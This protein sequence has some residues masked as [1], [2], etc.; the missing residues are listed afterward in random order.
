MAPQPFATDTMDPMSI[1]SAALNLHELNT[2]QMFDTQ[3]AAAGLE[4]QIAGFFSE[5]DSLVSS[6]EFESLFKRRR[7]SDGDIFGSDEQA[8]D[9]FDQHEMEVSK[10][11]RSSPPRGT[12]VSSQ[13]R[14]DSQSAEV[15]SPGENGHTGLSQEQGPL[16]TIE[17][18]DERYKG[19]PSST[20]MEQGAGTHKVS[21]K[22]DTGV[23][24]DHGHTSDELDVTISSI[25]PESYGLSKSDSSSKL[26]TSKSDQT[27]ENLRDSTSAGGQLVGKE[28]T[29]PRGQSIA[30]TA[31][32]FAVV[33]LA[34]QSNEETNHERIW[35]TAPSTAMSQGGTPPL[36]QN[37]VTKVHVTEESTSAAPNLNQP[38]VYAV[39]IRDFAKSRASVP[40]PS[41]A[42]QS[43][44][45]PQS[46]QTTL[47]SQLPPSPARPLAEPASKQTSANITRYISPLGQASKCL[48]ELRRLPRQMFAKVQIVP[49]DGPSGDETTINESTVVEGLGHAATP[50]VA[51]SPQKLSPN[52]LGPKVDL[53]IAAE[54]HMLYRRKMH[55]TLEPI[56]RGYWSFNISGW[57]PD[58]QLA[59]LQ[60]LQSHVESRMFGEGSWVD[61]HFDAQSLAVVGDLYCGVAELGEAW[62]LLMVLSDR[63]LGESD[64]HWYGWDG[65]PALT[66][67]GKPVR[68]GVAT[69]PL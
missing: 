62:L 10:D 14:R 3:Y 35:V 46:K 65:E 11:L 51:G 34:N 31:Q 12:Q 56:E 52:S 69:V 33:V 17:L 47:S 1:A 15:Q 37:D 22:Q 42:E 2:Q 5:Y 32:P 29:L 60:D 26:G 50:L 39:D 64:M 24:S 30:R 20:C 61:L 63:R 45:P 25:L 18:A 44:N 28:H 68:S 6:F 59:F 41:S 7:L 54:R 19:N 16:P 38:V 13:D 40:K 58:L 9:S 57:T 53:A 48:E 4:S 36:E 55:R 21:D 27:G 67:P 8:K 23:H 66:M 49:A 43:S